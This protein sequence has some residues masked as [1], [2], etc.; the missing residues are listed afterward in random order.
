MKEEE[1]KQKKKER[2]KEPSQQRPME[3][4]DKKKWSKVVAPANSGSLHVYLITKMP[5]KTK[6]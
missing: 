4:K 1:E 6:L 3:K 5:L 2:K